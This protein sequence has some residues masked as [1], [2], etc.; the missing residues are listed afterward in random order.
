[1]IFKTNAP[2]AVRKHQGRGGPNPRRRRNQED[3]AKQIG[4]R[5]SQPRH[6]NQLSG[7]ICAIPAKFGFCACVYL[8]AEG[9][10]RNIGLFNDT[11]PAAD[12]AATINAVL[13]TKGR[14]IVVN[15]GCEKRDRHIAAKRRRK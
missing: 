10:H 11:G 12:T 5:F 14:R 7:K 1:M 9:H 2:A 15:G 13:N 8:C 4:I 3:Q 6:N